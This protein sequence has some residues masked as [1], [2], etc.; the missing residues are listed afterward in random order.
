MTPY[1]VIADPRERDLIGL[2]W[3]RI[4]ASGH[5]GHGGWTYD[6]RDRPGWACAVP[7]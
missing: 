6:S 2:V 7:S 4:L 3:E 1:L 5:A